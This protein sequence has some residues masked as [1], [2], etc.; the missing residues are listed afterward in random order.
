MY[1]PVCPRVSFI[2]D[3]DDFAPGTARP[4]FSPHCTNPIIFLA[5]AAIKGMLMQFSHLFGPVCSR[6]LGRSL[7]IDLV[8]FKTCTYDCVYCECGH[9][10]HKRSER[11]EFFPVEE[12]LSELET[13]LSEGPVLDF[14]TFS[15]SGE[16]TLST[17]VGEVIRFLKREFPAY[18]VAVLTNGSLLSLP[19]VQEDLSLADVVLPTLSTVHEG[20]FRTIHRPG[21]DL[22]LEDIL[23]G[24]EQFRK[25][26]HGEIWL[27]VFIIPG[28]NTSDKEL[29]GLVAEIRKIRP[30]RIQL[31]TL[32]RPGSEVWVKPAGPQEL[33]RIQ[34]FLNIPYTEAIH[35]SHHESPFAPDEGEPSQR[36]CDLI[37]R[38][39][40]TVE[41]I[42]LTTGLHRNEVLKL[43]REIGSE[44]QI[45]VKREKRGVF[46]FLR[47]NR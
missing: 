28:V 37:R 21:D 24:I 27:E 15:G 2:A 40:C 44:Y 33:H 3:S 29:N 20:T 22:S 39:P 25:V 4:V 8:P 35:S 19:E 18:R 6:R 10:T 12:V 17:S 30:D 41:D 9:T 7:G 13:Y 14:I 36:I 34:A 5:S 45:L 23:K 11:R 47:G 43:L 42:A 26:Y 38:R 31:N 32:D 16:P 46:Y 1:C